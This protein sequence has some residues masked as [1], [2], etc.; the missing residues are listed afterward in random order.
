MNLLCQ[1]NHKSI[2]QSRS[3]EKRFCLGNVRLN[4]CVLFSSNTYRK[5][6]ILNIPWVLKSHYYNMV[7]HILCVNNKAWKKEQPQIV[8]ASK[9]RVLILSGDK[10]CDI[11]GHDAKCLTY[12]RFDQSFKNVVAVS[13]THVK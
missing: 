6:Q 13:L 9:Q 7:D 10:H 8:S 11:P 2:W 12:S 3:I 5:L 4:A 1:E